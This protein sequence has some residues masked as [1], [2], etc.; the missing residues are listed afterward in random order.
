M[1]VEEGSAAHWDDAY[2]AGDTTRSWFQ[3]EP[4]LSLAMLDAV[5]AATTDSLIDVGGGA[6]TL[7]DALLSRGFTDLTVLEISPAGLRTARQ[8]LGAPADQVRWVVADPLTWQPA[9]TYRIWHDRAV[10]H[11]LTAA[12]DSGATCTR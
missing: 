11:F 12:D 9:R 6:S 3:T 4:A 10:F 1:T 7:T 8:R 2:A 5:G